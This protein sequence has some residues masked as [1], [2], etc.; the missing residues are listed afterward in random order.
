[1]S[2]KQIKCTRIF[3]NYI[4]YSDGRVFSTITNRFLVG[5]LDKDGYRI[6]NIAGKH[7]K[8]HRLVAENFIPNPL[9]LPEV[10]HKDYDRA[11]CHEDNLE[12]T[13]RLDNTAHSKERHEAACAKSYVFCNPE[14]E[15]VE[16][17]NLSK[18]CKENNLN[19]NS[20]SKVYKGW[21]NFKSHKG[22]SRYERY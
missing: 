6:M 12:W 15:R 20:M 21:R 4:L 2:S 3:T 13:D 1:M 10:N 8:L 19:L 7:R 9:N 18:F 14:G 11:N 16:V 22:W 5:Y 17:F